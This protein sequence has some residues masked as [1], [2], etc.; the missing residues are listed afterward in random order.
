MNTTTIIV[1]AL[2]AIGAKTIM[3]PKTVEKDDKELMTK[4]EKS[5]KVKANKERIEKEIKEKKTTKKK[6]I[7]GAPKK[8]MGVNEKKSNATNETY[9]L[10]EGYILVAKTLEKAYDASK[11][12][13]GFGAIWN[14]ISSFTDL[15]VGTFTFGIAGDPAEGFDDYIQN[16][17]N[18]INSGSRKNI[19]NEYERAINNAIAVT[20]IYSGFMVTKTIHKGEEFNWSRIIITHIKTGWTALWMGT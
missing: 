13:E 8:A 4:K 5:E 7:F 19:F 3:F 9:K 16:I 12:N 11:N 1:L 17:K 2:L 6:H 20:K 18:A 14:A 10:I 15:V